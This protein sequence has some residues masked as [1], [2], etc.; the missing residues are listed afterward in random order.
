MKKYTFD[1]TEKLDRALH[2]L[3]AY[4]VTKG[5]LIFPDNVEDAMTL[6]K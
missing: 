2:D 1:E 3:A 4:D 6:Q 5:L